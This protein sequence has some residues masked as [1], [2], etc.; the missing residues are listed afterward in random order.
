MGT[1]LVIGVTGTWIEIK[2]EI[3]WFVGG[4]RWEKLI[5]IEASNKLGSPGAEVV[6][7]H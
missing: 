3:P 6:G 4:G 5:L 7:V 2:T 1:R